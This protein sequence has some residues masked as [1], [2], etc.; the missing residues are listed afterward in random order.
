MSLSSITRNLPDK[1][2]IRQHFTTDLDLAK[3]YGL[4]VVA[5]SDFG[6]TDVHPH[7]QNYQ[8]IAGLAKYFGNRQALISATSNAAECLGLTNLGH[9]RN[10]FEADIVV[11]RG[12]PMKDIEALS[13]ANVVNVLKNGR[14]V[15]SS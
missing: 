8:E 13:P 1:L 14:V 15:A 9:L 7:G 5:G 11:V 10:G 3:E 12:N 4:R 2:H 6:G